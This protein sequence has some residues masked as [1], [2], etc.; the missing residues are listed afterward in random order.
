MAVLAACWVTVWSEVNAEPAGNPVESLVCGAAALRLQLN[1]PATPPVGARWSS[2][3][4]IMFVDGAVNVRR[5]SF[6]VVP[7]SKLPVAALRSLGAEE[8]ALRQM[9]N[10]ETPP[11]E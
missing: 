1:A 2:Y 9:L 10:S 4:V 6:A 11:G 3:C 8:P 7:A 5:T